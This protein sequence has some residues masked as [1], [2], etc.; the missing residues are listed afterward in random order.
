VTE[1]EIISKLGLHNTRFD[2]LSRYSKQRIAASEMGNEYEKQTCVE[3]G[4]LDAKQPTADAGGFDPLRHYQIWGEVHDG[5]AWFM[6]GVA[7]HAGL[8]STS[9]E[10]FKLALLRPASCFGP[11]LRVG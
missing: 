1:R 10:V 11:I 4:Y 6:G 5:N 8:F 2:P 7:G 3:L 9:E